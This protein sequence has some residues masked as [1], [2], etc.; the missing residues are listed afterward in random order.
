MAKKKRKAP[1]NRFLKPDNSPVHAI[2]LLGTLKPAGEFSHT[3]T[4]CELL[5]EELRPYNATG[6][7]VRLVD[8]DIKPG[9]ES[10]MGR[11]DAWPKILRKVLAAD[12]LIFATPIWWGIQ[13]SLIQRVIERMDA[14]NDELLETGKSELANKVGGIVITGA[15]DG[16]QHIIGNV[17]DFLIW[18]G[19]TMPP[20]C[21]L[22]F[23]GDYTDQTH[24]SLLAKFRKNKSTSSMARTMARNL[25][26]FARLLRENNIPEVDEG[27]ISQNIAP[28]SVG[29]KGDR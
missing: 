19:I 27:A 16:A 29:M 24:K 3:E 22:S 6:E 28:G 21:S 20:A 14:L 10:N 4:L 5:L 15:E 1:T 9:V 2:V 17:C 18:N 11:G 23:L 13:S 12:I 25:V 8:Y 26:F 7:I